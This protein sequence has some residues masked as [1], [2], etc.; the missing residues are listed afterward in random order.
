MTVSSSGRSGGSTRSWSQP[1]A[2]LTYDQTLTQ[3]GGGVDPRWSAGQGITWTALALMAYLLI[4]TGGTRL[5]AALGWLI[6]GRGQSFDEFYQTAVG[7]FASPWGIW[8]SHI[9][10][11]ALV[12][13]IW[14][15][16]RFHHRRQL[17]WLWSVMPGVRWRYGIVCLLIATVVFGLVAVVMFGA[18]EQYAQG[19]QVPSGWG[20][21]LF[22][23]V[24]STPIQ[25]LGEEVLFRGYLIQAL[26]LLSPRPWFP[27]VGSALLFAILHGTQNPWLFASRFAFGLLAGALVWR[28]GGLEAGIAAHIMNNVVAYV[29]ALLTGHLVAARTTTEVSGLSALLE[30]SRFAVVAVAA[31]ALAVAM[32]VP[33]KTP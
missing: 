32:R 20:W 16:Y 28:T 30:I 11:G 18:S 23:I 15:I 9:G 13:V 14:A 17:A 22:A 21:Y 5:V 26:G 12:V 3:P 4:Y 29:L 10:L 33:R 27:I 1:A 25:A 24:V 6:E 31:G 7:D 8:A 19:W 2:G